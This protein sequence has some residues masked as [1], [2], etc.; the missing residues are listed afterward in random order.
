MNRSI[1]TAPLLALSLL[2]VV[3]GCAVEERTYVRGPSRPADRVEVVTARPSP[4][5]VWV[6]GR[7]D[8]HGDGWAWVE[9]RWTIH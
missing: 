8:Q 1:I 4:E 2:A 7:W 6:H 5:H 9:G 3:A